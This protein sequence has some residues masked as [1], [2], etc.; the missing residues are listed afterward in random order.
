MHVQ[1]PSTACICT[2]LIA[3]TSDTWRR[4]QQPTPV[5]VPR[6][7]HGQGSLVEYGSKG[8]KDLDMTK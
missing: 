1:L 5:F 8:H 2:H 4:E 7:F 6:E 3:I